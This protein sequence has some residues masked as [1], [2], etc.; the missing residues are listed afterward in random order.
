MEKSGDHE[1]T[2]DSS[3]SKTGNKRKNS[4]DSDSVASGESKDVKDLRENVKNDESME[5]GK[6]DSKDADEEPQQA[7]TQQQETSRPGSD[8]SID[9]VGGG[10]DEPMSQPKGNE[11][12]VY[13]KVFLY[14]FYAFVYIFQY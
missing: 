5:T 2:V 6:A 13:N 3:G 4:S 8:D 1:P 14:G 9:V 12:N 10:V 7:S 11:Q